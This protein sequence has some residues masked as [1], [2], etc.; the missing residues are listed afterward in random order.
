MDGIDFGVRQRVAYAVLDR[1]DAH[2][3]IDETVLEGLQGVV[4]AVRRDDDIRALVVTGRG[5]AFCLGLDL[6]LLRRAFDDLDYFH[7]VLRRYNAVL[8]AL[9][10]L[11]V[12]VV[13]A[14]NGTTRAG[15]F[16]LAL[17][18][19][20]VLIAESARIADH[21]T[22]FGMLPGGGASARAPRK[23]GDQQAKALL[24]TAGWLTGREAVAAG[25]ALRAVPAADLPDA[26]EELV[27]QL[28]T[29]SRACLGTLKRLMADAQPL[30]LPAA[31]ALEVERF[32][33][34]LRV[35]DDGHEG[36]RAYL[37]RRPPTWS[38]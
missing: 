26:V 1:P 35:Y 4:D 31:V 11:E 3:A 24:F 33:D 19:D 32:V 36:F 12:P 27:S 2:N 14:V 6:Q 34:Y 29:K 21:H 15:G 16:E 17:A 7:D 38:L 20:L 28:R 5:D 22:H 30:P 8:F 13:A 37:E 9:E 23:L 10:H 25:L 18:C